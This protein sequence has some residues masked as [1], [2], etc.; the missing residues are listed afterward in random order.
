MPSRELED[1]VERILVQSTLGISTYDPSMKNLI[2]NV[3]EVKS[4]IL[5]LVQGEVK[6]FAEELIGED[7]WYEITNP[8]SIDVGKM[9]PSPYNDLR[10]E[11][12]QKLK[13]WGI[14]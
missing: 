9:A 5:D 3:A 11:Q 10:A 8:D 7:E 6:D 14:K 12:R 1:K 2:V 4:A 13:E